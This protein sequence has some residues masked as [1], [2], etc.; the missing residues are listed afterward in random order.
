MGEKY[1]FYVYSHNLW[2]F[3]Y[4]VVCINIIISNKKKHEYWAGIKCEGED[5]RKKKKK[6]GQ[7]KMK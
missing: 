7:Q 6:R 5:N 1:S 3:K 4:F 2:L